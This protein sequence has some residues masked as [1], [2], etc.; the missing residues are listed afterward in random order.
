MIAYL[1]GSTLRGY[2][3]G[4][5]LLVKIKQRLLRPSESL[6][7]LIVLGEMADS[8]SSAVALCLVETRPAPFGFILLLR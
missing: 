1:A 6:A 3:L 5:Q 8:F 2:L 7:P 4:Y